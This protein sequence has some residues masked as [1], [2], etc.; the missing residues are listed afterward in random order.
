MS[1]A[2]KSKTKNTAPETPAS[3]K[4]ESEREAAPGHEPPKHGAQ[5]KTDFMIPPDH[6]WAGLWKIFA[7]VAAVGLVLAGAG[8]ATGG[9]EGLKHFPFGY[10]AAFAWGLSLAL[11]GLFFVLIQ[12]LTSA[13]WSVVV[14]RGAEQ[15]MGTLPLFALL[16]IPIVVFRETL[17]PWMRP[18]VVEHN[19][20]IHAKAGFL[21]FGFW[22]VRAVV[23]FGIWTFLSQRLLSLSKQQ[24]VSGDPK[25]TL[26]MVATSAPGMLGF[27]LSLTF[28]AFDWLM[29]LEPEWYSTMFGVYFF[30]GSVISVMAF[31]NLLYT[32]MQSAGLLTK[33]VTEEHFHDIGKLQF[34]FTVFWA[35][36][37][38]A[39]YMLIWYANIPEE[40]L[41]YM[42]RQENGWGWVSIV[43]ILGH[44]FFPFFL[45]LS[46]HAKRYASVRLVAA[47]W[48]LVMHHIDTYWLV[49]PNSPTDHHFHYNF[50]TDLGCLLL[51]MGAMMTVMFKRMADAPIV[52]ARD[53]RLNR[54]LTFENI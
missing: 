2:K 23:Y 34:A 10:L 37:G 14:R 7:G 50:L 43:L 51:V 28:A 36:I 39:Q 33:A 47:A 12:H 46:R 9:E 21:N 49:V 25:L 16:F 32:R 48:V 29:S 11:G 6:S 27:A 15:L 19:H 5:S 54:S 31:L 44:F 18:E 35:Y 38:F 17:F 52:P 3:K 30:A 42:H 53:P 20:A 22:I 4:P 40:T 8:I 41:F 45:M 24:D 13:G 1:A 26:K